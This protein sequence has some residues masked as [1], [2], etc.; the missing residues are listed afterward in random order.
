MEQLKSNI[1]AF[2]LEWTEELEKAVDA[3]HVKRPNPCP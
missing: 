3:I 2:D 1:D